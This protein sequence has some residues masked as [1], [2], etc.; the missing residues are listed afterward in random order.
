MA[1]RREVVADWAG[2]VV[3]V[4]VKV[5]VVVVALGFAEGVFEPRSD[6]RT[7]AQQAVAFLERLM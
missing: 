1:V 2:P 6:Q 7:A 5:V 3:V 4:V